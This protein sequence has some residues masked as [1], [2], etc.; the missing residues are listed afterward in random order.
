MKVLE[1]LSSTHLSR[2]VNTFQNLLQFA[3]CSGISVEVAII[4]FCQQAHSRLDKA[5]SMT[6]DVFLVF[7]RAFNII[8]P[9]LLSCTKYRWMICETEGLCV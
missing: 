1:R 2:Q 9:V 5:G 8:Q 7:P 6:F 4:Y 3:Y